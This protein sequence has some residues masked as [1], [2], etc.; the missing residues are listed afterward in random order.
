VGALAAT[1]LIVFASPA[2]A[3]HDWDYTCK[4]SDK[5]LAIEASV[6]FGA[7]TIGPIKLKE[8]SIALKPGTAVRGETPDVT[9]THEEVEQFWTDSERFTL[10]VSTYIGDAPETARLLL[11][12][13]CKDLQ[14]VGT[15]SFTWKGE[16]VVG[17][18]ACEPSEAG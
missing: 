11:D 16:P 5:A 9:F 4:A 10:S 6:L 17:K 8:A 15:Y 12:T 3:T 13:Q 7:G 1:A 14:C 2:S 18:L